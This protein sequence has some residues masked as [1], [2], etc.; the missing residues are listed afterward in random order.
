LARLKLVKHSIIMI[1]FLGSYPNCASN[2]EEKFKRAVDSFIL[3]T[4]KEK[5]LIIVSDGCEKTNFIYHKLYSGYENIKLLIAPKQ[6]K[7]YPGALRTLGLF[8]AKGDTVSYLDSDDYIAPKHIEN[9]LINFN[10]NWVYYD[11]LLP[12]L[13]REFLNMKEVKDESIN[14]N[15]K[16]YRWTHLPSRIIRGNLRTANIAHILEAR[17]KCF[18]KNW[19]GL[20]GDSE[21]W[22]FVCQLQ[23]KYGNPVKL[24][25]TG[26]YLCHFPVA[27]IDI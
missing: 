4:H 9:L 13:K 24:D 22:D 26:Y 3:N 15:L 17:E 16:P 25:Y 20:E 18:W 2:R 5:E 11:N 12:D 21:D 1:S 27:D 19:N 14:S 6:E 23:K 10:S 8:L 7:G